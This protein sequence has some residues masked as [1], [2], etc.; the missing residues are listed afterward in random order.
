M[1]GM[2]IS[3]QI[4]RIGHRFLG[5]SLI[6]DFFQSAVGSSK[7]IRALTR[8]A[9]TSQFD[10]VLDLGCGTGRAIQEL[11]TDS[12]YLGIDLSEKYIEKAQKLKNGSNIQ[13]LQGDIVSTTWLDKVDTDRQVSSLAWGLYH[14]LSDDHL[15]KLFENLKNVLQP[16]SILNSMDP[17]ILEDSTTTAK[18]VAKNDRGKFLREPERLLEIFDNF[19][20]DAD[21]EVKRNA[22]RI[23]VDLL[24]V[25]ATRR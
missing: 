10:F 3:N 13:L 23:P 18:W 12:K 16:G 4:V 8:S 21:F 9:V 14:H 20:F 7:N 22:I 17:V 25:K 19:G 5:N 2:F 11:P 24:I 6:Y 15:F 1:K